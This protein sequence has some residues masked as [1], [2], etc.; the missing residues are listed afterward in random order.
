M[1]AFAERHGIPLADTPAG[2]TLVPHGH[3]L[4][5]GPLGIVGSRSANRL[6]AEADL[7]I[8]IGTRLED[9]TTSSW[10]LFA[11]DARLVSIN[12]ARFDA[13][14]HAGHALVGDA[15]VTVEA[16]DAA[17]KG[18]SAD[19][20]WS[21]RPPVERG[22]WDDDITELRATPGADG[23]LT[24][25]QVVGAVNELSGPEDYVADRGRRHAR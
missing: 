7:V 19:A 24:Y 21:A 5:A 6:A 2:R 12:A 15:R 16:L 10:T 22:S 11:D 9:F 18:W 14:K 25:A 8:A 23:R 4:Y 17:L 1:L 3:P 20:S 13:V